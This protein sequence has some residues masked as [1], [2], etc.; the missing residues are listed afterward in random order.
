MNVLRLRGLL[1]V[2]PILGLLTLTGCGGALVAAQY[3]PTAIMAG[4]TA[5]SFQGNTIT[6]D[7]PGVTDQ[8]RFEAI[9]SVSTNNQVAVDELRNA[10]LF[11]SVKL[12]PAP[13][14]TTRLIAAAASNAG[15]DAYMLIES[16]GKMNSTGLTTR[17]AVVT[18]LTMFTPDGSVI[19]KRE[20]EVEFNPGSTPS[21]RELL[22]MIAHAAIL[23]LTEARQQNTEAANNDTGFMS[24][25][26]DRWKKLTN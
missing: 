4:G 22:D 18:N 24:S 17:G 9:Q 20:I 23:D 2:L 3:L 25:L 1:P 19:Y 21:D 5:Y 10:K 6:L 13:V 11:K 15:T 26:K 12:S 14:G 8:K 16:V 7:G